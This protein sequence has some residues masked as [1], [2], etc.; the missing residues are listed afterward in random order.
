MEVM[1]VT[2]YLHLSGVFFAFVCLACVALVIALLAYDKYRTNRH[3]SRELLRRQ[4]IQFS[5]RDTK[6]ALETIGDD[7][8]Y[9]F[10]LGWSAAG[11]TI[12]MFTVAVQLYLL[13]VFVKGAEINVADDKVDF[14][15]TFKCP[16]DT[17][18]CGDIS[19]M[20]VQGWFSYFI[21]MAAHLLKDLISGLKLLVLS[22]KQR[23]D[24]TTRT[25]Y[26][27]GGLLLIS[28]TAFTFYVSTI[29]NMAI[30]TSNTEII[31]N[32]VIILFIVEIDEYCFGIIDAINPNWVEH[33]SL[34]VEEDESVNETNQQAKGEDEVD[35]DV[36]PQLDLGAGDANLED[37]VTSLESRIETLDQS[38]KLLLKENAELKILVGKP[39][40]GRPA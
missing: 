11:W 8:V 39:Q 5:S 1:G 13:F 23:H 16:R 9:R 10:F 25:R 38:M 17:D 22:A 29:Y 24:F 14:V 35:Q 19:D 32:S 31:V 3:L 26:F 28:V 40:D 15:Y 4:S 27:F 21:L 34:A 12:V 6:Y 7:S 33:M 37:K 20:D 30:A 36:G 18:E 2:K